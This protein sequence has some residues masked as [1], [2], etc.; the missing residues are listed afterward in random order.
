MTN[1]TEINRR[2]DRIAQ[3]I[4]SAE[5]LNAVHACRPGHPLGRNNEMRWLNAA[6]MCCRYVSSRDIEWLRSMH[7]VKVKA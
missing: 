2:L 4:T 6:T 7:P 5:V 3:N 1:E